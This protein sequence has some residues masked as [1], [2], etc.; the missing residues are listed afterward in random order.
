M[1]A[2]L[3]RGSGMMACMGRWSLKP[4]AMLLALCLQAGISFAAGSSV[5]S[6]E[7]T[8][9]ER[10][11]ERVVLRTLPFSVGDAWQD[12]FA[13]TGERWLRNTGLFSEVYIEKPDAKGVVRIRV[14][15]RWSLWLL[16]QV[17]RSDNG[18][19]S[20]GAALDEYNLWGLQHHLR[21][22]YRRDTGRNFSA[23]NGDSYAFG[24]DWN[25]VADSKFSISA[26]ANWGRSIFDVYRNG[27]LESQ[28]LQDNRSASLVVNYALG[29]V[30]GE[31]WG[32]SG[33]F[34]GSNSAFALQIGPPQ[35]DVIGNR[36]RSLLA[37]ASYRQVDNQIIWFSGTAFDY[38]LSVTSKL[39]GSTLD[40]YRQ[41]ASL[42]S[43]IPVD[44]PNT[45]NMRLNLGHAFG[46][47]LRDGLFDLGNRNGVRGY[48]PGEVQGKAYVLATVEGRYLLRPD[49]NVQL[50][51][52]SDM[53]YVSG[54]ESALSNNHFYAGAGG[55]V[56]WTLRWL[57]RGTIRGDVAYGFA[58]GRWRFYVGTGQAF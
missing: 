21:L 36:K 49:S 26:A 55:G 57:V 39:F 51:A 32:V 12:G 38:S 9:L 8:G 35:P 46:D 4:A 29:P 52:F 22:A 41:T 19:S 42:R 14:N 24:Y 11:R 3:K 43:Y 53:A 18:A 50:V 48:F 16:P 54:R 1:A 31:G 34:S 40:V 15:E 10:T 20:I 17:S 6:I 37:G 7:I 56:R 2:S 13:A 33:G 58:T 45:L 5:T 23:D 30:P 28:Y 25:R 27:Q 44:G 47:V